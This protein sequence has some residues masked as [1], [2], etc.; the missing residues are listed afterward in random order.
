MSAE[1]PSSV[2]LLTLPRELVQAELSALPVVGNGLTLAPV[3]AERQL[4]D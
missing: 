1:T 2:T 3:A 4:L